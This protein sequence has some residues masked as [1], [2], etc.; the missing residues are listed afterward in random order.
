[1]T[2]SI[3][4]LLLAALVVAQA[5]PIT[6]GVL[7][8]GAKFE[9]RAAEGDTHWYDATLSEGDFLE[10]RA[11]QDQFPVSLLVRGPDGAVLHAIDVP[12]IDSLPARLLFVAPT[13]GSYRLELLRQGHQ[14]RPGSSSVRTAGNQRSL[15]DPG[16][17]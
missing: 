9:Q 2:P 4:F 5:P 3:W 17:S 15:G 1:M 14:D 13:S 16:R 6:Q 7:S 8:D 11:S 12:A 10:I